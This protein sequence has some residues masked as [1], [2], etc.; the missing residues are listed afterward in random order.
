MEHPQAKTEVTWS[1][2]SVTIALIETYWKQRNRVAIE[3]HAVD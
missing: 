3:H 2:L 1:F